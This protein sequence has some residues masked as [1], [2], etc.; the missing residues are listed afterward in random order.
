MDINVWSYLIM[1]FAQTLTELL[2]TWNL[3]F[4]P[5]WG[6]FGFFVFVFSVYFLW[7]PVYLLYMY[8]KII[9]KIPYISPLNVVYSYPCRHYVYG[10]GRVMVNTWDA[11]IATMRTQKLWKPAIPQIIPRAEEENA[12]NA[13]N[14]SRPTNMWKLSSLWWEKK[15]ADWNASTLTK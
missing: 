10:K 11:H 8:F 14:A 6:C 7:E 1:L 3:A 15:T 12:S 5:K 13:E 4:L 9:V 2:F